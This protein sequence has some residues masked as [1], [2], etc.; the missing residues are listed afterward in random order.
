MHIAVV[1]ISRILSHSR[2]VCKS[3]RGESVAVLSH[4][5]LL[6][7]DHRKLLQINSLGEDIRSEIESVEPATW[8]YSNQ[9]LLP[10][11]AMQQQ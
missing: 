9:T 11:L 6:I 3:S 2:G 5:N 10:D 4:P 8:R 7:H 1:H